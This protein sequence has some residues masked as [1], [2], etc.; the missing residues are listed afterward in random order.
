MAGPKTRAKLAERDIT[1]PRLQNITLTIGELVL[2]RQTIGEE[3]RSTKGAA[4]HWKREIESTE[5][6]LKMLRRNLSGIT[7]PWSVENYERAIKRDEE[8]LEYAKEC[9]ENAEKVANILENLVPK[10]DLALPEK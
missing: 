7:S 9:F 1:N 2:L 3:K 4:T 5:N 6:H 10:I 8:H